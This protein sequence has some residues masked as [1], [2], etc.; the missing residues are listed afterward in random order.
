M[1]LPI[2]TA[3]LKYTRV[4]IIITI[5]PSID[6]VARQMEL[7][8]RNFLFPLMVID[9][10]TAQQRQKEIKY[11]GYFKEPNIAVIKVIH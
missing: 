1:P 4:F 11:G 6:E 9:W 10:G 7:A 2:N 8:Y 5:F 3:R